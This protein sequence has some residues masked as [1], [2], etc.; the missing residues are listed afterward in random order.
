MQLQQAPLL[1]TSS[2]RLPAYVVVLRPAYFNQRSYFDSAK[3]E[4][5]RHGDM[6]YVRIVHD[7]GRHSP[8]RPNPRPGPEGGQGGGRPGPPKS[9]GPAGG[10]AAAYR[11]RPKEAA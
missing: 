2:A 7:D 4:G 6:A 11:P 3:T 10:Y 1:Y 8:V 5:A 9:R